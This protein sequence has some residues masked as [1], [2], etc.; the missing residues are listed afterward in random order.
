MKEILK[1]WQLNNEKR[2]FASNLASLYLSLNKPLKR[3]FYH[4]GF[5]CNGGYGFCFEFQYRIAEHLK[6]HRNSLRK[7]LFLLKEKN[8]IE[9]DKKFVEYRYRNGYSLTKLGLCFY[10][11]L[12]ELYLYLKNKNFNER[13]IDYYNFLFNFIINI[14]YLFNKI[15]GSTHKTAHKRMTKENP[16]VEKEKKFALRIKNETEEL[17]QKRREFYQKLKEAGW[18][19]TEEIAKHYQ[20]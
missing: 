11:F 12:R 6:I 15:L 19:P 3:T 10:I 1:E 16:F 5:R 13:R 7:Y 14:Y 4:I 9:K 17:W 18:N 2:L 20:I 8:L